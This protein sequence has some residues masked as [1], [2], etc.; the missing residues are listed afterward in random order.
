MYKFSEALGY[1]ERAQQIARK[2]GDRSGEASLLT[3]MGR[4]CF[5]AGDYVRADVYCAQAAALAA[6]V[7]DLSVQGL[8]FHNRSEAYRQLGQNALAK[9]AAEEAVR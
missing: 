1:Y 5:V 6:E 4:A 3:N 2:I 8:A 7:H 9:T